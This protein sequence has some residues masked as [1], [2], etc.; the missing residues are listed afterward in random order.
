MALVSHLSFAGGVWNR[1]I[2]PS[3]VRGRILRLRFEPSVARPAHLE[4][5]Q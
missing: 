5:S 3:V 2:E 1:P 4:W